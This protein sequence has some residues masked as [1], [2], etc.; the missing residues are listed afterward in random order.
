MTV[1]SVARAIGLLRAIND[2]DGTLSDL[3][4]ATD[5]PV[6]T[7]SRLMCTLEQTG[8][9][10]RHNKVWRI[11]PTIHELAGD[12]EST[13]DLVAIATNHLAALAEATNETAGIVQN[14]HTHYVHLGEV[15]TD[16][17]VAVKDWTGV[18]LPVHAGCGYVLMGWWSD[19]DIEAYVRQ[20][21]QRFSDRTVAEPD[22]VRNRVAK[23]RRDSLLWTVGEYTPDITAVATPV[24]DR[25]GSAVAAVYI[26]GPT[27][28]FPGRG[29]K[30]DIEQLLMERAQAISSV[31]GWT[32]EATS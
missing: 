22:A 26:H 2:T 19:A 32:A 8:A 20:P 17:D 4:R 7:V 16:H 13:F 5:L 9:V 1:T 15:A 21:L 28:R 29:Q 3:A 6:A 18:R 23:I 30:K 31:M 27:F 24:F 12:T 11:G 10:S 14:D 25:S